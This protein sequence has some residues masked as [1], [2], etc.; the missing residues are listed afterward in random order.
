MTTS[1]VSV[2]GVAYLAGA[3]AIWFMLGWAAKVAAEREDK[4]DD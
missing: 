3:T 1:M 2:D 4:N